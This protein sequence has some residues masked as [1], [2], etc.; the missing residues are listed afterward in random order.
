V[1]YTPQAARPLL[2]SD[3]YQLFCDSF[4][5][6]IDDLNATELKLAVRRC[7][8]A[9]DKYRDLQQ[10]QAVTTREEAQARGCTAAWLD[11]LEFQARAFYGG[12]TSW[13]SG[14]YEPAC[15]GSEG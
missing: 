7:R 12:G 13:R 2:D 14:S 10:R 11:T 9:R 1:S 6:A 5:P 3:E 15:R 8:S 4:E